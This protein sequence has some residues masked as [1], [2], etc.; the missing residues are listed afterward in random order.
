MLLQHQ[1]AQR[2]LQTLIESMPVGVVV[3]G[4]GGQVVLSNAAARELFGGDVT[5]WGGAGG[6]CRVLSAEGAPLDVGELPLSQAVGGRTARDVQLRIRCGNGERV[7]SVSAAPV[8][9]RDGR[10]TGAVESLVDITERAWAEEAL[11]ESEARLNALFVESPAAMLLFDEQLRY[12]RVNPTAAHMLARSP[13]QIVGRRLGEIHP[14]FAALVRPALEHAL[15]TGQPLVNLEVSG[16]LPGKPGIVTSWVWSCYPIAAQHGA[17]G[18][19]VLAVDQTN[20]RHAEQALAESELR[21]RTVAQTVPDILFSVDADG[22]LRY[23]N[24]RFVAYTGLLEQEVLGLQWFD[25]LRGDCLV[26]ATAAWQQSLRTG[27]PLAGEFRLRSAADEYRWFM[28]RMQPL[29]L[30]GRPSQWVGA[31]TDINE[32]RQTR[33]QLEQRVRERTAELAAANAKLT[34]SN[35]MLQALIDAAPLAVAA[36]DMDRR[37]TVWNKVAAELFGWTAQEAVGNR[38][39]TVPPEEQDAFES[40]WR[41]NEQGQGMQLSERLAMRKD[42]S[43]VVI[44]VWTATLRDVAGRPRGMM[45]ILADASQRKAAE[46]ERRRLERE[47]MVASD[48][49]RQ[50][51]G[52]DLHDSLGQDLTAIAFMTKVL[53]QRL[54][55][56]GSPEAPN[57][58]ELVRMLNAAQS[59]ARSLSHGLAGIGP[60][61]DDLM[62]GLQEL[63]EHVT[64]VFS[65]ECRLRC[66]GD[67][68]VWDHHTAMHLYRIAQEALTNAIKHGRGRRLSISLRNQQGLMLT[69]QDDGVGLP[70]RL[71]PSKGMGLRLMHYR[72]ATIGAQL[73][74]RRRKAG[75]TLVRCTLP[76]E[77]NLRRQAG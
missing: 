61:P 21:L 50:R 42:G 30:E 65:V 32:L 6:Q 19:A 46:D 53:Q 60:S 31:C 38:L 47:I 36:V 51:I 3:C 22:V 68:S 75:G 12:I 29:R 9:D 24:D 72:A 17:T 33:Q 2:V 70:R 16:E 76:P 20:R 41:L 14:A 39:R 4:P 73:L 63:C 26:A 28:I 59:T 15:A 10:I 34:E 77:R 44:D 55:A 25:L 18:I 64:E 67:V 48:A 66:H 40:A 43:R 57:A 45:A 23:V 8:A 37:V 62:H 1:D 13:D 27:E 11:R 52:Q 5:G 49:E 74:V 58:A 35:Q 69:I 54:A 56:A 7:V 71:K